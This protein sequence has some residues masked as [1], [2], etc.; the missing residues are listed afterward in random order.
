MTSLKLIS[1]MFFLSML[2]GMIPRLLF[3]AEYYE[4]SLEEMNGKSPYVSKAVEKNE[5]PPWSFVEIN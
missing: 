5:W 1:K 2:V 3:L 4:I